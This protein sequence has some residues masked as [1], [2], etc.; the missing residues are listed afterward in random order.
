ML[1]TA[2]TLRAADDHASAAQELERALGLGV[3][4]PPLE[5]EARVRL[6]DCYRDLNRHEDSYRAI[7]P[8]LDDPPDP[9]WRARALIRMARVL[10]FRADLDAARAACVDATSVLAPTDLHNDYA[11]AELWLAHSLYALGRHDKANAAYQA[12]IASAR[13]GGSTWLEAAAL[14]SFAHGRIRAGRVREA[15]RV[16]REALDLDTGIAYRPGM[17]K[18]RLHLCVCRLHTGDWDGFDAAVEE[19]LRTYRELGDRSGIAQ[20]LLMRARGERYR[21]RDGSRY[22]E[23]AEVAAA[24]AG[25]KRAKELITGERAEAAL[26]RGDFHRAAQMLGDLLDR[27]RVEDLG[28]DLVVDVKAG[29]A[30]ALHE[31]GRS[32]EAET[33]ARR[34]LRIAEDNEDVIGSAAARVALGIATGDAELIEEAISVYA[35]AGERCELHRAHRAAARVLWDGP[36]RAWHVRQEKRLARELGLE[37]AAPADAR[38]AFDVTKLAGLADVVARARELAH[39]DGGVLVTGERGVGRARIAEEIH[40]AARRPGP[41]V[42][43]ACGTV[44]GDQIHRELYGEPGGVDGALVRA[45]RGTLLLEDVDELADAAQ[46]VVAG[47]LAA[48]HEADAAPFALVA[49]A[50]ADLAERVRRGAFRRDLYAQIASLTLPVPSLRERPE[51]AVAAAAEWVGRD[52]AKEVA[53]LIRSHDWPGNLGEVRE[54][55]RSALFLA[56]GSPLRVDHFPEVVRRAERRPSLR[57]RIDELETIE[58]KRALAVARGN[59][60]RAAKDLGISRKGLFDRLKRLG[61]WEDGDGDGD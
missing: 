36:A 57:A 6:A 35:A 47:A 18:I 12:T 34:A 29:L 48:G 24:V 20:A 13:R 45:R 53:D 14:S 26:D 42:R 10:Y 58:I 38:D 50:D 4:E 5:A 17:S 59:K 23:E 16:L 27:F 41:L 1:G 11:Q 15:E 37:D 25:F 30:R 56:N 40:R 52:F 21:G 61:L 43:L 39:F 32:E 54:A 7:G 51:D 46:S 31:L 3:L 19:A 55:V 44:S 28:E 9:T 49:T 2:E 33:H 8:L 22:L 60:T